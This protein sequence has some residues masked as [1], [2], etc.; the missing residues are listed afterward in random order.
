[1]WIE[2]INEKCDLEMNDLEDRLCEM[3]DDYC[4]MLEEQEGMTI[5][6]EQADKLGI[7]YE[8]HWAYVWSDK[9]QK[10]ILAEEKRL[11]TIGSKYQ[12]DITIESQYY[13]EY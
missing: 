2:E 1:M 11:Y 6:L 3:L 4:Q 9:A 12:Q 8:E 7:N 5:N 10:L 13:K